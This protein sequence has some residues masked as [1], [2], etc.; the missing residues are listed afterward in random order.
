VA[1]L[2]PSTSIG[3]GD[4]G[5][6]QHCAG[7][8][9]RHAHHQRPALA[10]FG[11]GLLDALQRCLDLQHVLAGF[12]DE[13]IHIAG[14]QALGL[15]G[16]GIAQ[17][18]EADVPEGGQ[19]GGGA[20]RAGHEAG[21]LRGAVGIGHLAGQFGGALVD[22]EGLILQVVFRQHGGGG[23]KGVGF[24]HIAAH[25]QELP[26]HRLHRIGAGEHQV[27]VAALQGR[28]AEILGAQIHLLQ[29]GACGAVEHEHRMLRAVQTLEE[30]NPL[31]GQ[32]QP[33]RRTRVTQ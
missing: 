7:G 26:V 31:G 33:F 19:L 13:Q 6:H 27:F 4:V 24:D 30:T 8:F 18:I 3:N 32:H 5:T 16:E 10:G 20:H 15:F 2:S 14:D 29:R 23:P 21:F 12:D 1:Q 25:L 28:A 17:F 22:R 11:E 9:H